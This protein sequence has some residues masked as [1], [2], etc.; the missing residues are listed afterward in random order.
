[1]PSSVHDHD[2][3]DPRAVAAP[4][5][6]AR[7]DGERH[8]RLERPVVLPVD[9]VGVLV[10]L[11]ADAVA[12]AVDERSP[13]PASVITV[14]AAASTDSAV[15]PGRACAQAAS[16]AS[17]STRKYVDELRRR[18][19]QGVHPGAVRAVA[20][21]R[22]PADVDDHDVA[23]LEH[24]VADLVVRRGAV[25]PGAD[26]DEVD[27]GVALVEDRRGDV[28]AGL[29]LG[30]P[31][32]Q[33]LRHPGV[34]PVDGLAGPAQRVDLLGALAHPQVAEHAGGQGLLGA[35]QRGPHPQHL[36]GPHPVGQGDPLRRCRAAP[37]ITAYGSSVSPQPTT[38][39]SRSRTG[40][41]STAGTSSPGATRNGAPDAGSTR[42]VSRSSGSAS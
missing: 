25:G 29:A 24:P 33:E 27:G 6:D 12:G 26:D 18:L 34:H 11:H 1:M 20:L 8:A 40:E 10:G 7:L 13:Y 17:C 16:W 38:S 39:T 3:L 4:Q 31:G 22:R 35:R 30:A 9:D 36:L 21:R 5:V 41:A 2:V 28:P 32:L 14:R 37:A 15:T 19:A 42:Q 23:G